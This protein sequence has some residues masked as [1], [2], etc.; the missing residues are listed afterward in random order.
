MR[1][2]PHRRVGKDARRV[3]LRHRCARPARRAGPSRGAS[4][5]R[6][7]LAAQGARNDV[8]KNLA[9]PLAGIRKALALRGDP[10]VDIRVA[11]RSG[12]TPARERTEMTKRPRTSS[13]RP[14]V[15]LHPAHQRRRAPGAHPC[16]DGHRRRD[17]RARSEQ[18]RRAPRPQSRASRIFDAPSRPAVARPHWLVCDA[19]SDRVHRAISYGGARCAMRHRGPRPHARPRPGYR[20]AALAARDGR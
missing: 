13:S 11:V 18:A 2:S 6:V 1:S 17:P 20:D 8:E 15:A 7:R 10:D 3:P 19:V 9:G 5:H 4:N 16:P 12:D 14:G